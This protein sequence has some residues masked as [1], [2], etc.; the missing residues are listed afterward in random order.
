[1]HRADDFSPGIAPAAHHPLMRLFDGD[2]ANQ[3]SSVSGPN[4][5]QIH[6]P[7]SGSANWGSS[8]DTLRPGSINIPDFDNND[9][10]GAFAP[11]TTPWFISSA[12]S[13][14]GGFGQSQTDSES[15]SRFG[16]D[17]QDEPEDASD[18][19]EIP[20]DYNTP[21]TIRPGFSSGFTDFNPNSFPKRGRQ[22]SSDSTFSSSPFGGLSSG[23][24]VAASF[25]TNLESPAET[26]DAEEWDFSRTGTPDGSSASRVQVAQSPSLPTLAMR[27]EESPTAL[28]NHISPRSL[29]S[30]LRS[31]TA[32]NFDSNMALGGSSN[33]SAGKNVLNFGS[34]NAS[35]FTNHRPANARRPS[36][37]NLQ[38]SAQ[39]IRTPAP[40]V[41]PLLDSG[42]KHCAY[43]VL[44]V[45]TG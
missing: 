14:S 32:P 11:A 39:Q 18:T 24:S 2:T 33:D 42:V 6:L 3:S 27:Q 35:P 12:T 41:S 5:D 29:A 9:G 20:T 8:A 43:C 23:P 28:R 40:D 21:A 37:L 1:M 13:V 10:L 25:N 36:A 17:I 45:D 22:P 38:E 4:F 19:V 31:N 30:R 7:S 26:E 16:M 15:Y 44:L 34:R